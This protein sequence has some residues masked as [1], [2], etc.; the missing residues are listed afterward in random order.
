VTIY[1]LESNL[2]QRDWQLRCGE[3]DPPPGRSL[4]G[5]KWIIR[6]RANRTLIWQS[7]ERGPDHYSCDPLDEDRPDAKN[8]LADWS[9]WVDLVL[10]D[11]RQVLTYP[12]WRR[13]DVV[14]LEQRFGIEH[15]WSILQ[16]RTD[17]FFEKLKA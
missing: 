10:P 17:L 5:W 3:C 14:R 6:E 16:Q 1:D 12:G 8:R 9:R 7:F 15:T 13:L 4:V 11:G 2:P